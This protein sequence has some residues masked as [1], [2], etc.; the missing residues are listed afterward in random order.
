MRFRN[1][2]IGR[3]P[4]NEDPRAPGGWIEGARDDD[5]G[6]IMFLDGTGSPICYWAD[7][8]TWANGGGVIGDSVILPAPTGGKPIE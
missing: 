4:S 6:W 5:S 2:N 8:E 7:R 3:Y 1:I